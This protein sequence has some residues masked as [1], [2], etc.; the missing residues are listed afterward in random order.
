MSA[1]IG[2]SSSRI[3]RMYHLPQS[4]RNP[5]A[6]SVRVFLLDGAHRCWTARADRCWRCRKRRGDEPRAPSLPGLRA[7][8]RKPV[9]PTKDLVCALL[10]R[11]I[12]MPGCPSKGLA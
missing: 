5:G 8:A 12:V 4:D 7:T 3:E 2:T 9:S 11:S 1:M 10:M 6:S